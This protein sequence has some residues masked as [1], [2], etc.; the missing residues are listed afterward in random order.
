MLAIVLAD[1]TCSSVM[2]GGS[3]GVWGPFGAD[4]KKFKKIFEEAAHLGAL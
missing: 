3:S 2:P 4:A 1:S